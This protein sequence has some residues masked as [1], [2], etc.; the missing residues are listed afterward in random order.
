MA[1][2]YK[3]PDLGE[4]IESGDVARVLVSEG[5]VIGAEQIVLELETDKALIEVPSP[6]A[7]KVVSVNVKEGD[8]VPV[9]GLLITVEESTAEAG[10]ESESPEAPKAVD[11]P[12]APT[13]S[14]TEPETKPSSP[15]KTK[16]QAPVPVPPSE[17][18]GRP[19]PAAPA[20]RR[21][22]RELGVDL[23]QVRGTGAGGRITREDVK[24]HVQGTIASE[25]AS[26]APAPSDL[27]DFSNW[28][29]I[30]RQPLRAVRR[31]IGENLTTA[32]TQVPH[33]TQ[34]DKADATDLES[35]R[36]RHKTEAESRGGRL[37]PTVLLLKAA[38]TALKAFPQFNA[39]LDSAAGEIVLKRYYHIGIAVDTDRG[40]LV[41]VIRDVDRKDVFE[42]SIELNELA[43]RTRQ[44]KVDLQELQGGTFTV[45]NLG[46]ISGTA[47]T[48]IVNHPEVAILGIAQSRQEPV[49]REGRVEPRLMMPLCLSY[50]HRVVDGADGARFT[51]HLV[52]SLENP[53]RMLLGG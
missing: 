8:R 42:L 41:P 24:A 35:F 48:P 9:G 5:D 46:S 17:G 2:E 29:E 32:W 15:T 14:P 1:S 11:A 53:E 52:E 6:F 31:K 45:T 30:E 4:G 3:L 37:T 21:F 27:P 26:G 28:G 51:K 50:D 43:D 23:H 12:E 47:F 19:A 44:G 13:P 33:V 38:V 16:T 18:A 22:A 39:S 34:F 49:I 36:Q 40:L 10:P 25:P 20:T 7:G